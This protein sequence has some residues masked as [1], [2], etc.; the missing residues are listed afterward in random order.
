MSMRLVVSEQAAEH[1]KSLPS[2]EPDVD[3]KLR[4]LLAREYRRRL[5]RYSLTDRRLREKYGMG[6]EEFEQRNVVQ[7]RNFGW[8]VESDAIEWDLAVDGIRTMR[9]RLAE[10]LSSVSYDH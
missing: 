7:E 2:S 4:M 9:R 6:F 3:G 1:L 10:L 5:V 8:D